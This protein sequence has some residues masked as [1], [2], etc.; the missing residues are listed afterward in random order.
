MN[1]VNFWVGIIGS[2]ILVAGAAYPSGKIKAPYKSLKNWLFAIGGLAMLGYAVL[3]YMA[4]GSIFFVI[5][6]I[7]INAASVLMMLDTPDKVDIP[8]I[9]IVGSAM[10]AWSL[11][12]FEGYNTVFFIIGLS[13]IGLGYAFDF[14]SLRREV[15]LTL[16]SILIAVFSYIEGDWI[17]LGLNAFFAL[18]SGY[19][20]LRFLRRA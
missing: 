14:G 9:V 4:G 18:F 6:Q 7:F 3:N 16:G 11:T 15:A 8:F 19:Y 5:L 13:G 20:A 2:V 17:F 1:D 12:L 10:I